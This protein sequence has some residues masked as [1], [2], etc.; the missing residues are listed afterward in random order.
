MEG[1]AAKC[2]VQGSKVVEPH[3]E[4]G[5][6]KPIRETSF[7]RNQDA[8]DALLLGHADEPRRTVLLDDA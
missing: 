1:V 4:R 6:R 2:M 8:H 7:V 3:L 5:I